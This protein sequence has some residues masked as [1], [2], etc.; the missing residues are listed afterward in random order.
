MVRLFHGGRWA[1]AHTQDC[2]TLALQDTLRLTSDAVCRLERGAV[3]GDPSLGIRV[4]EKN[5]PERLPDPGRDP[6]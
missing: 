5:I 4:R 6:S 1:L 3:S 2:Y